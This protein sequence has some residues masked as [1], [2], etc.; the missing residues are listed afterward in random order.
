MTLTSKSLNNP[1]TLVH[2]RLVTTSAYYLPA[3][4]FIDLDYIVTS[5]WIHS[6]LSN[7]GFLVI[8]AF[9]LL[10]DNVESMYSLKTSKYLWFRNPT[11]CYIHRYLAYNFLGR[12]DALATISKMEL[13]L[14]WCMYT[15]RLADTLD[16]QCLNS[17][18]LL[19]G[20]LSSFCF[21]PPGIRCAS[22]KLVFRQQNQNKVPTQAQPSMTIDRCLE[23]IEARLDPF[24]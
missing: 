8:E 16:A 21:V 22:A 24:G 18:R 13:F 3:V 10:T 6:V 15:S 9:A 20:T 7:F 12:Q 19:V 2:S 11:L 14:L 1:H 4:A 5:R 23:N 17:M